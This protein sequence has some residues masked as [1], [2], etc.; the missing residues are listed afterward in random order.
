M[1]A[2]DLAREEESAP[3]ASAA[4]EGRKSSRLA[5]HNENSQEVQEGVAV[6]KRKQI[7]LM[8]RRNEERLQELARK[9]NR[10]SGDG[11][12][13]KPEEIQTF[14]NTKRYPDP[15]SPNQVKVEM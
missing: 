11:D 15:L 2:Y 14:P 4:G 6:R 12:N 5:K 10:S 8:K 9:T 7:A 13:D 3:S 1:Q